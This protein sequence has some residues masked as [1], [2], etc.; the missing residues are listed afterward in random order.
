MV[1]F[2]AFL[3]LFGLDGFFAC[4]ATLSGVSGSISSFDFADVT[5][6][7]RQNVELVT[8]SSLSSNGSIFT[9]D[10]QSS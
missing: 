9:A 3:V 8:V 5:M 2:G 7:N 10:Y 1:V 6:V 4:S